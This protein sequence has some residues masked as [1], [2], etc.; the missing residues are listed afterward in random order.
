MIRLGAALFWNSLQS[1]GQLAIN[2]LSLF[3]LSRILTPSD[4]G[5]YGILMI[6]ISLSELI[7][8]CG[9]GGYLIKKKEVTEI[10][11]DTLFIY[12]MSVSV[13]LYVIMYIAAPFLAGFYNDS[14]LILAIRILGVVVII[15]AFS[16]TQRTRLLKN[17]KFKT[18]SLITLISAAAGFIVALVLAYRGFSFWSL[19]WQNIIL[20]TTSSILYVLMNRSIPHCRFN[21]KVFKEQFG[22]GINLFAS[23]VLQTLTNNISNNVI[24]KVFNIRIT[25]LYMQANR[26]QSY[27]VSILT[28]IIDRTFFPILSKQSDNI[29]L[30]RENV[31]KIQRLL[32]AYMM[33]CFTLFIC[34]AEEIIQVV[35]GKQWL[36]CTRLFQI[37]MIASYFMLAKS[38]NRS[39]LKSLGHTFCILKLEIYT[40][41][42]LAS[43]LV[44][45]VIMENLYVLAFAVVISQF[46]SAIY[47]MW[48][49]SKMA[50]F[51]LHKQCVSFIIFLIITI[52][53]CVI[54]LFEFCLWQRIITIIFCFI[55]LLG[56]SKISGLKEYDKIYE[57]SAIAKNWIMKKL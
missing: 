40:T 14:N 11:Y 33:P 51:N 57:F 32:Y 28:L 5:V 13:L 19:I 31:Y 42:A 55:L 9:I 21:V 36:E 26:M 39:V 43:F 22:F 35:L 34:F 3:V 1:F 23:S 46:V 53:P 20:C 38:M 44:I 48:Y 45:S 37:L 17:L 27:P 12:N 47:S 2:L 49:L 4:Y 30:L 10:Y 41:L 50:D 18:I 29:E 7:A 6:F 15:Q 56:F 54:V 16:I 52:I 24:A 25:G 8:D